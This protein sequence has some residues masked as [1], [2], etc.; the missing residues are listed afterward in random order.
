MEYMAFIATIQAISALISNWQSERHYKQS[1][2]E[3]DRV[4]REAVGSAE[5]EQIAAKLESLLPIKVVMTYRKNLER[6]LDMLDE[7]VEGKTDDEA[8]KF[9]ESAYRDCV[10]AILKSLARTNGGLPSDLHDLWENASCGLTP[11]LV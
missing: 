1:R 3:F 4:Y 7:C 5:S 9:C 10:C 6:C 8:F 11:K 2:E